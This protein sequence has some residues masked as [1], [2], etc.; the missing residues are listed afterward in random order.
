MAENKREPLHIDLPPKWRKQ[1]KSNGTEMTEQLPTAKIITSGNHPLSP[2]MI[3]PN[4]YYVVKT[5]QEEGYQ[6]YVVGGC[7]RDAFMGMMPKDFDVT[8][9]AT[10]EQ[11]KAI[12]T[13]R[14]LFIGK[15]FR[16]VHVKFGRPG[17]PSEEIIEVATFRGSASQTPENGKQKV[18]ANNL[19]MLVRDNNYGTMAEDAMRRDF[20]I[21]A[22]YYDPVKDEIHDFHGGIADI[23]RFRIDIIGDPV[24]RYSEDP[25]RMLRA[26]R[27]SAKLGM[28]ITPRTATPIYRMGKLLREVSNARMFDEVGKLF[29]LGYARKTLNCMSA[30]NMLR[31]LFP[32]LDSILSSPSGSKYMK[33]IYRI[34]DETDRRIKEGGKPNSKFLYA[35]LLWP[36]IE[37]DLDSTP[38]YA[39][40]KTN[41]VRF[42]L[43]LST[44]NEAVSQQWQFTLI[45]KFVNEDMLSIWRV[46]L[47]L[48]GLYSEYGET[49][50][51]SV[52]KRC[53]S[54]RFFKASYDFL[55]YRSEVKPELKPAV[56]FWGKMLALHPNFL[57]K[58][59]ASKPD[60]KKHDAKQFEAPAG[61]KKKA[62]FAKKKSF[63]KPGRHES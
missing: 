22:L 7:V 24:T 36:T 49:I 60:N 29:L 56:E 47:N 33:F 18:V 34:M 38:E 37:T 17:S 58:R 45:P 63:A 28:E 19:G 2:D 43:L 8:T 42:K 46:Q 5:L 10:P 6:A 14:A 25:V 15:R 61:V 1:D 31:Q 48:E 21:N 26:V 12:F 62:T 50:A 39:N 57:P 35:C 55:D 54:E 40:A 53:M 32:H 9:S 30:F 4:A 23:A 27:F 44:A 41:Q 20:T 16:I 3:S 11:V 51:E 52:V 59:T 13:H